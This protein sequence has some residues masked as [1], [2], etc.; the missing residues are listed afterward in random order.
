LAACVAIT[1]VPDCAANCT[2]RFRVTPPAP[3]TR[4][5]SPS[6][7]DIPFAYRLVGAE[8][9]NRKAPVVSK[10]TVASGIAAAEAGTTNCSAKAP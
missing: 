7:I 2:S 10:G 3:L 5:V 4:T 6:D 8:G 9:Q 1:R